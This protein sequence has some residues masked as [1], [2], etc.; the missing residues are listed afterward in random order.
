[1]GESLAL[2][3]RMPAEPRDAMRI[4]LCVC[5]RTP[6]ALLT[7]LRQ[8]VSTAAPPSGASQPPSRDVS[9][10]AAHG[11]SLNSSVSR[12]QSNLGS[13]AHAAVQPS[14]WANNTQ[15]KVTTCIEGAAMICSSS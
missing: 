2:A 6:Q 3:L 9:R 4:V 13:P 15:G 10:H 5:K 12:P 1:M 7:T 14:P 11:S 8:N